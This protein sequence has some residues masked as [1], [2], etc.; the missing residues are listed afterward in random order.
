[1][2]SGINKPVLARIQKVMQLREEVETLGTGGPYLPDAD[3]QDSGE[4]LTLLLDVPGC[5][6]ETLRLEHEE[7]AV[8]VSGS[9][10]EGTGLIQ[11]ERRTGP[12]SRRLPF[13]EPV[14]VQSA[15]ANLQAG[16]L[17]IRFEKVHKTIDV[18]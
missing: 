9:R 5:T 15:Q 7:E 12:F 1:M 6:P 16:V 8:T 11:R 14:L 2:D 18:G 17:S 13:P 10:A 3:W 4:H